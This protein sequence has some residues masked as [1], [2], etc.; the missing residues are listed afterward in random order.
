MMGD[1]Q[2]PLIPAKARTQGLVFLRFRPIRSCRMDYR[3]EKSLGPRV[4]G[5]ERHVW[6]YFFGLI[7]SEKAT[8]ESSLASWPISM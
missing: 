6:N 3:D 8:S 2:I 7:D 4:R 1:T 5:D